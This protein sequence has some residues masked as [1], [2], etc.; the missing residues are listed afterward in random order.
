M[1]TV[2]NARTNQKGLKRWVLVMVWECTHV[3]SI[4]MESSLL[5]NVAAS[6][7]KGGSHLL[8]QHSLWATP[9][10]CFI[11]IGACV[12]VFSIKA[13]LCR[14]ANAFNNM[15]PPKFISNTDICMQK[16]QWWI[17]GYLRSALK[18][19]RGCGSVSEGAS[20]GQLQDAF[21]VQAGASSGV[22]MS[23]L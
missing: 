22:E 18:R 10:A 1:E 16:W 20:G 6:H 12:P 21:D 17:C 11:S 4:T 3:E 2:R 15:K 5:S 19:S 14:Q 23:G 7:C 9:A 8:Q 13:T